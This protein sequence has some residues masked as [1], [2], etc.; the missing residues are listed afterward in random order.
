M[1]Y[2]VAAVRNS[3]REEA[4][5][6]KVHREEDRGE[7]RQ[8]EGNQSGKEE[9]DEKSGSGIGRTWEG[10]AGEENG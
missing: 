2:Q 10:E 9:P 8:T 1:E 7:K 3:T 5:Q 6:T 4:Q